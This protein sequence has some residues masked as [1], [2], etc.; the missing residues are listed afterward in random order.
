MR[1]RIAFFVFA[2][3]LG[4]CRPEYAPAARDRWWVETCGDVHPL[5]VMGGHEVVPPILL[6]RVEPSWPRD[7]ER[8][9][10]QIEAVLTGDGRVCAARIRRGFG[11]DVNHAALEAV[12][13]WRFTPVRLNGQPRPAFFNIAVE[14]N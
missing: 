9:V 13:Q 4:A 14:V 12:K 6:E 7:R 1:P 10:I 5:G 11:D 8:G 2:L 3:A